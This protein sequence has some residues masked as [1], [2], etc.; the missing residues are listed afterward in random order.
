MLINWSYL[1]SG[2]ILQATSDSSQLERPSRAVTADV[3]SSG[4]SRQKRNANATQQPKGK[5]IA[6]TSRGNKNTISASIRE[7]MRVVVGDASIS[8][9]RVSNNSL[10][11]FC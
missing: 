1:K 2:V 3:G 6:G 9:L 7:N 11:H 5:N 4:Q 10:D 8:I